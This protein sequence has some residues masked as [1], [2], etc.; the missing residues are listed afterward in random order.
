MR[1]GDVFRKLGRTTAERRQLFQNQIT[2]LIRHDRIRT[3]YAKAKELQR[4]A[5][6]TITLQK[7]NTMHSIK[8]IR[9][10]LNAEDVL[11][12]LN[13]DLMNRYKNRAGG[14]TRLWLNGHR[15][16]D[17]APMAIVELLDAPFDMKDTFAKFLNDAQKQNEAAEAPLNYAESKS[18]RLLYT[19]QSVQRIAREMIE[20]KKPAINS[21]SILD[22][23][24]KNASSRVSSTNM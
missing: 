21:T 10:L 19:N 13:S 6:K 7:R 15:K 20:S 24:I 1:H 9:D 18:S 14:Y 22:I 3:T 23:I 17:N 11:K 16:G 5:E 2:S 4:V 12:K 8:K